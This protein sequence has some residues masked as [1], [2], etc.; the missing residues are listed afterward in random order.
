MGSL[1]QLRSYI[2]SVSVSLVAVKIYNI[3]FNHPYAS[4]KLAANR[5]VGFELVTVFVG[6]LQVP[7]I[8][9]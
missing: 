7:E 1:L 9:I 3:E 4:K 2:P 5:S 8:I 6:G